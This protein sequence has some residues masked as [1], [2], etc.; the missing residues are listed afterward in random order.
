MK[1]FSNTEAE[2]MHYQKT[3]ACN[4]TFT[5]TLSVHLKRACEEVIYIFLKINKEFVRAEYQIFIPSW[6]N[7]NYM[8]NSIF[9]SRA[10]ISSWVS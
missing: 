4:L 9:S 10:E 8:E 3:K 1:K 2:K 7:V 6:K 5:L